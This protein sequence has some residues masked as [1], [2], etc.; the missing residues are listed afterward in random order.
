MNWIK[1]IKSSFFVNNNHSDSYL[2]SA[3]GGEWVNIFSEYSSRDLHAL[4]KTD[5][6]W[7]YKGW[8]YVAIT[9]IANE[10]ASLHRQVVWANGKVTNDDMLKL[11]TN[12]LLVNIVSYMKLNGSCYIRKNQVGGKVTELVVLR[13]D[14]IVPELNSTRTKILYY[15]YTV[16]GTIKEIKPEDLMVFNNFNPLY[17]YPNNISGM[18]DVQAIA[19]TIDS[20]YQASKWQWKFFY[21]SARVDGVLETD[22]EGI[23][24]QTVTQIQDNWDAKYRGTSNSHKIAVL[25]WWLKYKPLNPS[26]KEMDF[27]ESRRFNRD[28]ILWF[29]GVP[30]ATL[31]LWEGDA[32]LNVRA[33]DNIFARRTILP[34]ARYI[35]ESLN[36]QLFTANNK[37]EFSNIVPADANEARQDWINNGI[38]LNEFRALRGFAPI[39]GGDVFYSDIA[40]GWMGTAVQE[41]PQENPKAVDSLIT[42]LVS[43]GIRKHLDKKSDDYKEMKWKAKMDRTEKKFMDLYKEKLI[44][45]FQ[46]Q[47]KEIINWFQKLKKSAQK[48]DLPLLSLAKW[49][50]V[51]DQVLRDTQQELVQQEGDAALVDIWLSQPFEVTEEI[52]K[53][54]KANI[55]KFAMAIDTETNAKLVSDFNTILEQGLSIDQ[56][57]EI[58]QNRFTELKTVRAERIVRTEVIRASNM[59]SQLA[60]K[61][62]GVVEKK[63]RYTALDE[64]VCPYCWPMH[65]KIIWLDDNYYDK[66]EVIWGAGGEMMR[67]TYD[68]IKYA[69]LHPNCRCTLLPV[70]E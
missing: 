30:K 36:K 60:W 58:L 50:V 31:W 7:F 32:A 57:V 51:Y 15:R 27:V 26:Q 62:S 6:L 35:M 68:D 40:M 16:N 54:L 42:K 41:I 12:E 43:D 33:F 59:G 14:C 34:L 4:S 21:N 1:T 56:G 24:E 3:D 5:Y 49:R 48:A 45:I 53:G 46:A 20:D 17:P 61:Q 2:D 28:E 70:V 55:Y 29:F 47:Q 22:A 10:I 52:K 64:R 37:F 19:T 63:E 67:N 23:A 44:P 18:P 39:K 66:G 25:T 8:C 11:I 65:W 9:T 38:T 13:P 69:P